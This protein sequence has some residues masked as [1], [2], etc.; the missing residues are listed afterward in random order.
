MRI[1]IYNSKNQHYYYKMAEKKVTIPSKKIQINDFEHELVQDFIEHMKDNSA[2]VTSI[3]IQ[4]NSYSLDFCK[5]FSETFLSKSENLKV[6][7]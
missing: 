1:F 5:K 6:I 3:S 7:C 2:N 4:G